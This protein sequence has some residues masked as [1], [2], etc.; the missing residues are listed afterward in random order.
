MSM[1]RIT[2]S[3]TEKL[4]ARIKHAAGA[5]P[6]STWVTK[7]VE[8]HLDDAELERRFE[9]FYRSVA[10]K[11]ADVQRAEAM[12]KRLTKPTRRRSAA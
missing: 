11:R 8:A 5:T 2:I 12:F 3:V 1:R 4:G 6:V 7:L 9:E 10:P